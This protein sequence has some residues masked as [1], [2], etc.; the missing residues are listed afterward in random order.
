MIFSLLRYLEVIVEIFN[1]L[2]NLLNDS[3][4]STNGLVVKR[5]QTTSYDSDEEDC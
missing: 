5:K 4:K 1:L 3:D 2:I